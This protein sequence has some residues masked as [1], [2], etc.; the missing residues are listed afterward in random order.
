[1]TTVS[2]D[3]SLNWLQTFNKCKKME[4]SMGGIP[5]EFGEITDSLPQKKTL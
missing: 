2:A 1:M 3:I 4:R 5:E